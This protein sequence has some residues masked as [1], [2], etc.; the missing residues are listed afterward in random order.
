MH[1]CKPVMW[2]LTVLLISC[3]HTAFRVEI[4]W[5]LT[6]VYIQVSTYPDCIVPSDIIRRKS[7]NSRNH[8]CMVKRWRWLAI[9]LFP[10]CIL[11]THR[12]NMLWVWQK[13]PSEALNV[14]ET[15]KIGEF[16]RWILDR[17]S[18]KK[19]TCKE[20]DNTT[21]PSK[22]ETTVNKLVHPVSHHVAT[23]CKV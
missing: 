9:V 15:V 2:L 19:L 10:D 5:W 22:Y 12:Q 16:I 14:Q 11:P 1:P 3:G 21:T 4:C 17:K 23:V 7:S 6:A 20:A 8:Q 13:Y 18:G